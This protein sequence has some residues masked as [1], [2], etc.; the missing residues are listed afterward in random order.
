MKKIAGQLAAVNR[1][2]SYYSWKENQRKNQHSK[3][4]QFTLLGDENIFLQGLA[5]AI[6]EDQCQAQP[7]VLYP[8]DLDR[9]NQK[10]LV[11]IDT[12]YFLHQMVLFARD[13]NGN[14]QKQ[15]VLGNA[16][17][18]KTQKKLVEQLKTVEV[19]PVPARYQSLQIGAT[20]YHF[21]PDRLTETV[22]GSREK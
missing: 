9:D 12:T 13:N 16:T 14:W 20:V 3:P 11:L 1:A 19:R 7:C 18:C 17:N 8:V 6:E 5:G 22:T 4:P 2:D 21:V 10:E 15:G